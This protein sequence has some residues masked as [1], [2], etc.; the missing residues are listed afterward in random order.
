MTGGDVPGHQVCPICGKKFYIGSMIT[1][2]TYKKEDG[3]THNVTYFCG[4]NCYYKFIKEWEARHEKSMR[5][6]MRGQDD[7]MP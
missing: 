5:K 2:W 7:E 1:D 4:W 6:R 3:N